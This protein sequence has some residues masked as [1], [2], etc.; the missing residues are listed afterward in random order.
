MRLQVTKPK[1]IVSAAKETARLK[2]ELSKGAGKATLMTTAKEIE[3]INNNMLKELQTEAYSV[4]QGSKNG[5]KDKDGE[6]KEA[7]E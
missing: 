6:A 5:E 1:R 2:D 4:G 7:S 3:A